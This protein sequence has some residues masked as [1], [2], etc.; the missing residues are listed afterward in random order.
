MFSLGVL[1]L[2]SLVPLSTL[3]HTHTN[4]HTLC[5]CGYLSFS[6]VRLFATLW[7]WP[8]RLLCPGDSPDNNIVAGCHVLLQG[9]SPIWGL[10]P[11]LLSLLHLQAGSLPLA[12]PGRPKL[13][14]LCHIPSVDL[15]PEEWLPLHAYKDNLY[16]FLLKQMCPLHT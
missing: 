5:N 15:L 11:H 16:L 8:S 4:T 7:L 6:H 3:T 10:N 13:L 12:P 9:I 1:P 2:K 14:P